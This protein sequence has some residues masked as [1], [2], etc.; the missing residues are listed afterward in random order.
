MEGDEAPGVARRARGARASEVEL[1]LICGV[2]VAG[3][4]AGGRRAAAGDARG[5]HGDVN[6][7]ECYDAGDGLCVVSG[8]YDGIRS[9]DGDAGGAPLMTFEAGAREALTMYGEGDARR[10][11]SG[12]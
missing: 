6:A 7:V 4:R 3:S 1:G 5:A 8:G 11:V 9:W 10:I 12:G 2:G